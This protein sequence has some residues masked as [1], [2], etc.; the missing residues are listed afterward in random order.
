MDITFVN[1]TLLVVNINTVCAR[2]CNYTQM[3]AAIKQAYLQV[4]L[5]WLCRLLSKLSHKASSFSVAGAVTPVQ[6]QLNHVTRERARK[7]CLWI[8]EE[9]GSEREERRREGGRHGRREGR[10]GGWE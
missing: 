6:L 10:E 1:Q 5:V 8:G 2:E 7:G 3:Y 4:Q 9:S